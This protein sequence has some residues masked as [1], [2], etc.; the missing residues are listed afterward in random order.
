MSEEESTMRTDAVVQQDVL[1]ELRWDPAVSDEGIGATVKDGVVT[2]R[3]SVGSYAEKV[4]AERAAERVA[5]VRAV[6][7][8]V[9]VHLPTAVELSDQALAGRAA[10]ALDWVT[11]VPKGAV[12][13]KIDKSGITLVGTVKYAFQRDMAE[14][15]VR[16]LGG[17]VG[18]TNNIMVE[19]PP[20][21]ASGVKLDIESALKRH[22]ELDA[23]RI[24]VEAVDATVTL[25]GSVESWPERREVERAAWNAPGVKRVDNK[26]TI[27][28]S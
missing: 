23:S 14:S 22:A 28:V 20:V 2:L 7:Q 16:N 8:E 12:K 26:L 3:G 24:T 25:R 13:A 1:A 27:A 11:S 10:N 4:A 15:A 17:V 18:V 6:A 19:A 9:E 5:G 21:S